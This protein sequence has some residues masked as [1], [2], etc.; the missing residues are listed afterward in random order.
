MCEVRS[1]GLGLGR[2]GLSLAASGRV[3]A[4]LGSM[5]VCGGVAVRRELQTPLRILDFRLAAPQYNTLIS[6]RALD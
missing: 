6:V 1:R 3:N 5:A 4:V 2:A